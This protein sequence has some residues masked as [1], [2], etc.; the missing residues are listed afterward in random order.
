MN[1]AE[2][3][4]VITVTVQL[5]NEIAVRKRLKQIADEICRN[6]HRQ[7]RRLADEAFKIMFEKMIA[8][9]LDR[10]LR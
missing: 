5:R 6:V 4:N 9:M 10:T 1:R 8:P 2:R 3:D 7:Q